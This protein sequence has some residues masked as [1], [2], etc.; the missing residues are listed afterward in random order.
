MS[1]SLY[2]LPNDK[3]RCLNDVCPRKDR[4]IR[5]VQ[6]NKSRGGDGLLAVTNSLHEPGEKVCRFFDEITAMDWSGE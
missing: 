2:I 3:S 4:C 1:G 5:W 6:R